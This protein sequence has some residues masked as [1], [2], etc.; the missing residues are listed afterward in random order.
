MD[1]ER[2][3]RCQRLGGMRR[4]RMRVAEAPL[5]RPLGASDVISQT[6]HTSSHLWTKHQ[7]RGGWGVGASAPAA[8]WGVGRHRR[9]KAMIDQRSEARSTTRFS[10]V[11]QPG[12]LEPKGAS[13]DDGIVL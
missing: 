1:G 11:S 9:G 12:Q 10:G 6:G 3:Q 8:C 7:T 4:L 13:P 5:S 2:L